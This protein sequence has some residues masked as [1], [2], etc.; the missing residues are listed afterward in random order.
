MNFTQSIRRVG[1]KGIA[2]LVVISNLLIALGLP[3][4]M[5]YCLAHVRVL[6]AL[7][8]DTDFPYPETFVFTV[9]PII[10]G[11]LVLIRLYLNFTFRSIKFRDDWIE[12]MSDFSFLN[13]RIRITDI[14]SVRN[15][16][17]SVV[18]E[19]IDEYWKI[20]ASERTALMRFFHNRGIQVK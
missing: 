5:I 18:I 19:T 7:L 14:V 12:L 2:R 10:I 1:Q 15:E 3:F 8:Y 13:Q 20:V 6:D 11:S 4:A 17:N 16:R 9:I